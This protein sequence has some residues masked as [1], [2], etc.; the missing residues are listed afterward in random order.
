MKRLKRS[1][2]TRM[3]M[4]RRHFV[5]STLAARMTDPAIVPPDV[6]GPHASNPNASPN[7][8]SAS[9]SGVVSR[10]PRGKDTAHLFFRLFRHPSA[11]HSL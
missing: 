4:S 2:N 7:E 11:V 6:G 1:R 10:T 9:P 8:E 3:R 5:K